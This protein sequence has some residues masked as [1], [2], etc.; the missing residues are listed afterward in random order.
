MDEFLKEVAKPSW[1]IGVVIVGFLINLGSA[2]AKPLID[3]VLGRFWFAS[4]QATVRRKE[5]IEKQAKELLASPQKVIE[6]KLD[7]LTDTMRGV[8]VMLMAVF[9][10]IV[11]TLNQYESLH[12]MLFFPFDSKSVAPIMNTLL[13]TSGM[14]SSVLATVLLDRSMEKERVLKAYRKLVKEAETVEQEPDSSETQHLTNHSTG[15][16]GNKPEGR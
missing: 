1:W 2:Y 13:L 7:V 4:R 8:F 16:S 5:K 3:K 12:P 10:F 14:I 9:L 11:I 15:S 6:L